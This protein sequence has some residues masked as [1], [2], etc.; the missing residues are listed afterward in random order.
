LNS[1]GCW[2]VCVTVTGIHFLTA[3]GRHSLILFIITRV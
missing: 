3:V 2:L 1:K